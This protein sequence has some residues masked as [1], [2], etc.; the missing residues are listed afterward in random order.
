MC[1]IANFMQQVPYQFLIIERGSKLKKQGALKQ[2]ENIKDG[3]IYTSG[4]KLKLA[5]TNRE[6]NR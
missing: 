5:R 4:F 6:A 2:I 1:I 3:D